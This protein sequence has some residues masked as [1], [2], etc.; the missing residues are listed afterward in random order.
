MGILCPSL[1]GAASFASVTRPVSLAFPT[2]LVLTHR[3]FAFAFSGPVTLS[4][5]L[6][7]GGF[8]AGEKSEAVWSYQPYEACP[9]CEGSGRTQRGF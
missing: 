8:T 4:P 6:V 5:L 3:E 7:S 9:G 1:L 2:V